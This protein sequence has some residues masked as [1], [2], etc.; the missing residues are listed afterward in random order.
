M[1]QNNALLL[2]AL[3]LTLPVITACGTSDPQTN[4]TTADTAVTEHVHA[5]SAYDRDTA[6]HWQ[7]CSCGEIVSDKQ[8]HTLNDE[9]S[10]TVCNSVVEDFGDGNV[11]I[12]NYDENDELIRS[13]GY[14]NGVLTYEVVSTY[15]ENADGDWYENY[16]RSVDYANGMEIEATYNEYE[17]ILTRVMRYTEDP[18]VI[19]DRWEREYNEDGDVMWEKQ[20]RDDVLISEI[21]DYKQSESADYSVRYPEKMID[22]YDDGTTFVTIN[23]EWGMPVSETTYAADGSV[24]T[25]TT[26]VWEFDDAANT[27]DKQVFTDGVLVLDEDYAYDEYGYTYVSKQT[28]YR[29]DGTSCVTEYYADGNSNYVVYAADGSVIEES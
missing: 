16:T 28:E 26:Y 2:L 22:Y 20:Y 19:N 1:K 25:E 29:E 10:C 9:N 12:Y 21:S 4:D 14:E 27:L 24:I 23:G 3:A 6:D 5:A 18:S 17:D 11:Y 7:I 13:S 8:A 15:A